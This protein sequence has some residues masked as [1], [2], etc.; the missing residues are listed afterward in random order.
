ML[1][2]NDFYINI[3]DLDEIYNFLVLRFLF[4]DVKTLKKII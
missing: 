1:D 3:V 4:D 2:E